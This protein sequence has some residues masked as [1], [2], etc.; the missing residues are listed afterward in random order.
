MTGELQGQLIAEVLV[1]LGDESVRAVVDVRVALGV[2]VSFPWATS[3]GEPKKSLS[4]KPI[5]RTENF[6]SGFLRSS[7]L[8][9]GSPTN[10]AGR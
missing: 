6:P 3:A 8:N 2:G 5:R 4:P 7:I 1:V 10:K 9:A